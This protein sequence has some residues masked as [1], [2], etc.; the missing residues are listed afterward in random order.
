MPQRIAISLDY[1]DDLWHADIGQG[2]VCSKTI[3][4]LKD[5]LALHLQKSGMRGHIEVTV[6]YD[7]QKLPQWLWQ[8]QSYYFERIWDLEV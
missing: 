2:Q 3:E 6:R 4:G 5:A 7:W 8:Y 1:K